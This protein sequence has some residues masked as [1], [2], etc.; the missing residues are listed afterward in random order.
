[1]KK[2]INLISEEVT[3]AFVSAGYD[4]KYGK[5]TL[6]N[7]PDLCEFQCN[8]AMAAAKEYKCAPFMISDK[9]AAL[10]ESDE[11]FES[12]ESVKPG[13]LNI[14]MDTAF[15][16]KYMNDMKDDEGRYGLEKAICLARSSVIVNPFQSMSTCLLFKAASLLSQSI[17]LNSTGI[18]MRLPA[19]VARSMSKPTILPLSSRKPIGGKLSSRPMTILSGSLSAVFSSPPQPASRAMTMVRDSKSENTFFI[20]KITPFPMSVAQGTVLV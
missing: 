7:R 17:G 2:L 5:V 13:F 16:A 18:P 9:V 6:S 8:G 12:V 19:S 20:S 4:E 1:M 14:K 3:K 11:M 15:L 10:L